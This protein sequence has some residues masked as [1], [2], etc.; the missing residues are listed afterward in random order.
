MGTMDILEDFPAELCLAALDSPLS[1]VREAA[2]KLLPRLFPSPLPKVGPASI[3]FAGQFPGIHKAEME[4]MLGAAG[5][6][7]ERRLFGP[8]SMIVVAGERSGAIR[9]E[10]LKNGNPIALE[11]HLEAWLAVD[12][13]EFL[14]ASPVVHPLN[15]NLRRLVRSYKK[16]NIEMALVRFVGNTAVSS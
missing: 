2:R 12:K 15:E 14:S 9:E 16:E 5:F 11:G 1:A 13:G 7:I 6:K 10:A 3:L 4:K 8:P